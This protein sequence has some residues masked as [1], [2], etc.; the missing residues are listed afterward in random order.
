VITV[1]HDQPKVSALN[2]GS[3][4]SEDPKF[5]AL[6]KQVHG[7]NNVVASR[8]LHHAISS[9]NLPMICLSNNCIQNTQSDSNNMTLIIEQIS[10]T[11]RSIRDFHLIIVCQPKVRADIQNCIGTDIEQSTGKTLG[12]DF[13]LC[14]VPLVLSKQQALN[15]F[16]ALPNMTVTTSDSRS[17]S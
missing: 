12:K 15:D 2:Q 16:Y 9:T 7:L 14:F 4:C 10:A 11:L 1:D 13:D 8:D 3:V 6:L 5:K 17:E